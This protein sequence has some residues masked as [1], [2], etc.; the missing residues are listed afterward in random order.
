MKKRNFE[1]R[2]YDNMGLEPHP[3]HEIEIIYVLSGSGYLKTEETQKELKENDFYIVN[4]DERFYFYR[5]NSVLYACLK[6]CLD[7]VEDIVDMSDFTFLAGIA[8][9][10][11]DEITRKV[12]RSLARILRTE[13]DRNEYTDILLNGYYQELIYYLAKYY[14]VKISDSFHREYKVDEQRKMQINQYIYTHFREQLSLHDLAEHLY[15][16]DAYLSKYMK[17]TFGQNFL[18]Y[19]MEVRAEQAKK[20]LQEDC[21]RTVLA[22][23]LDNG[24]PN[25]NSFNKTF[26]N[27]YGMTPTEYRKEMA[28]T[29]SE[30]LPRI[31]T[32]EMRNTLVRNM[33]ILS[34]SEKDRKDDST[35][36]EMLVAMG[37]AQKRQT[38]SNHWNPC[39]NVGKAI[40]LL[41]ADVQEQ[42][43]YL[44]ETLQ[45]KYIR[46]WNL[47][48]GD[49]LFITEKGQKRYRY[50]FT[51]LDRILEFL[52]QNQLKP[53]FQL[54]F[55]PNVVIKNLDEHVYYKEEDIIFENFDQYVDFIRQ[56]MEHLTVK[57][58]VDE[59]NT[60]MF[61]IWRSKYIE[62][63]LEAYF[64]LFENTY[65]KIREYAPEAQIG[66]MGFE[67]IKNDSILVDTM[68]NWSEREIRPDFI[69]AYAYPYNVNGSNDIIDGRRVQNENYAMEWI[70]KINRIKHENH[71]DLPLRITEW[72][73]SVS[74]RNALH[75]SCFM[76]AYIVKNVLATLNQ[77]DFMAYWSATD[78]ETEHFDTDMILHGGEGIL[79]RNGI[80]K[81]AYYAFCFLNQLK[82]YILGKGEN[83]IITGNG[84]QEYVI[85][86]YNYQHPN[87]LYYKQDEDIREPEQIGA[88]FK[89]GQRIRQKIQIRNVENGIYRKEVSR[90]NAQ[91]GSVQ[92]EILRSGLAGE[93][94]QE[95]I[96]YL[97]D[98][99]IPKVLRSR[100]S[101]EEN[102]LELWTELEV[103]EIQLIRLT[104]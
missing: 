57:F 66:G 95:E 21:G 79:S 40:D 86:C 4:A 94:N 83:Y 81:P 25:I 42:I 67:L 2:L 77:V 69:T 100:V 18:P 55:K 32:K 102:L 24:F 33:E 58:G 89:E 29:V 103:N 10:V 22:I 20:D 11:P 97:K 13:M 27:K 17:K 7:Q 49:M 38:Y 59:I 104:R 43:L 5:K 96:C 35:E 65:R 23:A 82:K 85:L 88:L 12:K 44:K 72:N 30:E 15:L 74:S 70:D 45:I 1:C 64:R 60:W 3:H 46:C 98:T 36:K 14:A 52:V 51:R 84:H 71:M 75:D 53:F 41:R 28:E 6:I 47:F 63:G 19:L 78:I 8:D 9:K 87:V 62:K 16:S 39:I 31:W 80:R 90:V 92:D 73:V 76:A 26:Q 99:C 50:N 101:C 56:W 48:S 54:V 91:H 37:D 93:L 61:E 68:R 34:A